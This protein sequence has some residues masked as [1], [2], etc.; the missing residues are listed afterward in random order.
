MQI[1]NNYDIYWEGVDGKSY[2]SGVYNGDLGIVNKVTQDIVEVIFD[3]EKIV[4]YES[5]IIEELEHAYAITI[6]KSQGSEFPVGIMIITNGPPM[7]YTRNLLY[8]GVTRAKELLILLGKEF[9]INKMIDNIDTK[10]R[11]TG[12]EYKLKKYLDIFNM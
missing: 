4:K 10:K 5:N 2:G 7:L 11:N 1:R 9:L 8:T 12:L 3:D 6:H